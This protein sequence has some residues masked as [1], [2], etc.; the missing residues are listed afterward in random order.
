VRPASDIPQFMCPAIVNRFPIPDLN[1]LREVGRKEANHSKDD[2]YLLRQSKKDSA[3][4]ATHWIGRRKISK[5]DVSSQLA[6]KPE[7]QWKQ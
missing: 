6:E 3:Q 7:K 5:S 2:G 1:A 4:R